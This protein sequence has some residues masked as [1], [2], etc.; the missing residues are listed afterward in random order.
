MLKSLYFK[1]VLILIVFI[2]AVMSAVG[3]IL[4]NG[5]TVFYSNE[6]FDQMDECFAQGG[7][8]YSDLRKCDSPNEM[9][10]ILSSYSTIL[11]I[12]QY[13]NYYILDGDGEV[14]EGSDTELA[15]TLELT[16]N[17]LSAIRGNGEN[18][19]SGGLKYSDWAMRLNTGDAE[20][21]ITIVYVK[22]SLDE[23]RGLI[24]KVVAII[25]QALVV[26]IIIAVVLSFFLARSISSPIQSLTYGTK[27]VA[28]GEFSDEIEVSSRDEI[29]VLA[30]SFNTMRVRLRDTIEEVN[31]EREKLDTV[32]MNMKDA[33]MAFSSYGTLIHFNNSAE[34]LFP[35]EFKNKGIELERCLELLDIPLSVS[36]GRMELESMDAEAES[37]R[38]GYIFRNR[39]FNSRVY[40]VSLA[41]IRYVAG[42]DQ[43]SGCLIIA[44]DITSRYE[45]E[46][47]R[48]EFVANV[49]HELRTPLTSIKG[50]TETVRMDP[51]MDEGTR[52]YFLDMV[53]S[54]SDRMINLVN[55]L[56]T[57]SRLDDNRTKWNI[58]TYDVR[59]SLRHIIEV[60]LSNIEAHHHTISFGCDRFVP[61]ITADK[62]R[63]DQVFINII[64]NSV[65]YTPD[66]GHIDV[67]LQN[68]ADTSI[69]VTI[70][71]NGI[72]V[73]AEDLPHLFDRF[74]R[75]EKSRTQDAG[76][77]GLGLAIAKELVEAHGGTIS[78]SS[79]VGSGTTVSIEVPVE[80]M[81]KK[82]RS[83]RTKR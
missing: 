43:S 74:Y 70:S 45:L 73:P 27:L 29:G 46:E 60:M 4:M 11:G 30:E 53:L 26:G 35:D 25:I 38:D 32:L 71:D 42:F 50:A 81:I 9:K 77:T 52:E 36:E 64:S 14:L 2:I 66:G 76:G 15:K 65:K 22:D 57:L 68:I 49:S 56:L 51:E 33:V 72:G 18:I 44:H 6:F 54:E 10:N 47:S 19:S 28:E 34:E 79:K 3:A 41:I 62:Q 67:K 1:I 21:E 7:T 59:Q 58:E 48:R 78:V 24:D 61:N 17:I 23:M 83:H 55:D 40:D 82:S 8:L 69:L 31:G 63:L 12:D 16:P 75:V 13:R 37:T 80:C 5:I 20:D 39:V